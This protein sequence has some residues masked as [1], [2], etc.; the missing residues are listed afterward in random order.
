MRA[1]RLLTILSA[2][3]V[4]GRVTASALAE[5]LEVSKRTIYRDMDELS[6]AGIPVYAERGAEGGFRLLD[7]YR[8][9]LTGLTGEETDALLLAGLPAAAADLGLAKAAGAARLKLLAALPLPAREDARRV[10]DRFHL[11]PIDW[12]RRS[13]AAP[14]LAI[15]AAAVWRGSRLWIDYE[16]WRGRAEQ[17]V[18]PLG[19]VLKAGTWYLAARAGRKVRI[20]RLSNLHS[21]EMI[22]G[23]FD[24]PPDFDLS[25]FWAEEV[26]RFETSLRRQRARVRMAESALSRLD[27]LPADMASPLAEALPDADG[28]REAEMWIEGIDNAAGLL[29]G[30]ADAVEVVEPAALRE[31][32]AERAARTL[33]LYRGSNWRAV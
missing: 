31:A 10:A 24:R 15:V 20:Y 13:V 2:L 26:E 7:A 11:D 32:I 5:Q 8:T 19:L 18:D 4:N 25:H 16:S 14:Q 28:W 21:A 30:F 23:E 27:R 9:D 29:L 1:S 17:A 12:Y 22:E 6:A 3:Q 33:A